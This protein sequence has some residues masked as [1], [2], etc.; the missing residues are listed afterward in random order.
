M[1]IVKYSIEM[2]VLHVYMPTG[3]SLIR[4]L[5]ARDKQYPVP[6]IAS[7]DK[8]GVKLGLYC[9]RCRWIRKNARK[10]LRNIFLILRALY[11]TVR[12]FT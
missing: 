3:N 8:L 10:Y 7:S 4:P 9:F 11:K 2:I 1:S 6:V 5:I 12:L